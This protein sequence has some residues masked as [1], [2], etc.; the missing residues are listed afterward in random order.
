MIFDFGNFD[1]RQQ[2]Q[3]LVEESREEEKAIE[4]DWRREDYADEEALGVEVLLL[5]EPVSVPRSDLVYEL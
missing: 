1:L 3:V 5:G 4:E 2:V